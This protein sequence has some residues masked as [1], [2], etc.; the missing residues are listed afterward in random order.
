MK[1]L[2]KSLLKTSIRRNTNKEK[3]F[4][5]I[6]S[7]SE[8]SDRE[9][10]FG[11][12]KVKM[13]NKQSMVDQVFSSVASKYDIMNDISSLGIHRFWKQ[14]LIE[15]IGILKPKRTFEE[16]KIKKISPIKV[17]DVATGTGD[18]A[19]KII[20]YQKKHSDNPNNLEKSLQMTLIDVNGDILEI[21]KE[22]SETNKIDQNLLEFHVSSAE[23]MKFLKDNTFDIYVISFGLRNVPDIKKAL[24][25][26]FRVLKPGG[27]FLCME[28]SKVENPLFSRVYKEYIFNV[29]PLMGKVVTDDSES[30]SYLAESIDRFYDQESLKEMVEQ[31]GF[32]FVSFEN[33]TNG[34]CAIHS[35]FKLD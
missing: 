3:E 31:A 1:K 7:N 18:I 17:L 6:K 21:A 23:E 24:K 10:N 2:L 27:R 15:E 5:D 28:F 12:K 32:K 20:E 30:Y 25:E 33:L 34:V 19:Y 22:K 16:G 4:I 11:Y 26:A 35:G 14:K 29:I 13:K 9:T 8:N